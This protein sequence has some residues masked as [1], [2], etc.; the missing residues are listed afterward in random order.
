M[1]ERRAFRERRT[2]QR[3]RREGYAVGFDKCSGECKTQVTKIL[4]DPVTPEWKADPA[5]P[6]ANPKGK[7][8]EK[9][10]NDLKAAIKKWGEPVELEPKC[11]AGCDCTE[12]DEDDVDWKKKKSHTRTF[13]DSFESK[14]NKKANKFIIFVD[15]EFKVAIVAKAC[16]E[17]KDKPIKPV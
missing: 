8:I 3:R 2:G 7:D 15:V 12:I 13:Q 6:G 16:I 5:N 10:A 17:P 4:T 1:A 14:E 9:A 11:K